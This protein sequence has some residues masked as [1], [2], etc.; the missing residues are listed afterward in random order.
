VLAT[1]LFLLFLSGILH[2]SYAKACGR[3]LEQPPV[4]PLIF[5]ALPTSSKPLSL[6]AFTHLLVLGGWVKGRVL[7]KSVKFGV[8]FN[9]QGL[10]AWCCVGAEQG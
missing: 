10:G 1:Y 9:K 3:F 6:N 5:K 4:K 8:K 7:S 2:Y